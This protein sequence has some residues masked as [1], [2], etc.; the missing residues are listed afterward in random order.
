MKPLLMYGQYEYGVLPLSSQVQTVIRIVLNTLNYQEHRCR[1][2]P[3]TLI[4]DEPNARS[5]GEVYIFISSYFTYGC[6]LKYIFVVDGKIF[7]ILIADLNI[8][9]VSRG[10]LA[11]A[12]LEHITEHETPPTTPHS[13]QNVSPSFSLKKEH[14]KSV[15][16]I[17]STKFVK[18]PTTSTTAPTPGVTDSFEIM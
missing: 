13:T 15:G 8:L 6:A 2:L 16:S 18:K 9:E 17:T 1:P 11:N 4:L 12:D 7:N 3:S 14:R 10:N 5:R